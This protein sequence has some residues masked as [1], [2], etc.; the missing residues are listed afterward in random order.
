M[1]IFHYNDTYLKIG[2]KSAK[3]YSAHQTYE[4]CKPWWGNI[5][6]NRATRTNALYAYR[7]ETLGR[8]RSNLSK[9]DFDQFKDLP[10]IEHI[11]PEKEKVK[12][13]TAVHLLF[14]P[15][16]ILGV[17][18]AIGLH[19]L[20]LTISLGTFERNEDIAIIIPKITSFEQ[21]QQIVSHLSWITQHV[22]TR[23][24]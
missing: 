13:I 3:D 9:A 10:G 15:S 23:K 17:D 6:T 4:S 8:W 16:N 12:E 20:P 22:A 11:Y 19:K 5:I 21:K 1:K 24:I 7:F 2:T 14:I 18:K